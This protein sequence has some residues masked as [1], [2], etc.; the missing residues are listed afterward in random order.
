[1][2]RAAPPKQKRARAKSAFRKLRLHGAYHVAAF[3]AKVLE[4]PFWFFEQW[5]GRL[6]DQ[7]QNERSAP[8]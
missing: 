4:K 7:L 1:M 3:N 6:A 8:Q 5:R 2:N